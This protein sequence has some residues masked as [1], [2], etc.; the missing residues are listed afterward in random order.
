MKRSVLKTLLS[1][2]I[3][4]GS[5]SPLISA[6]T[7]ANNRSKGVHTLYL[8]RHGD[9]NHKDL[10]DPFT[11]KGLI[12][13]GIAQ[14]RLVAW[15]LRAIPVRYTNLYSS[16]MRRAVETAMVINKDFPY[17]KLQK[18]PILS[19]CTPP[20]WRADVMRKISLEKAKKCS[21]RLDEAFKRFF[22][23]TPDKDTNDIVVCH[24]NVIR[25][26]VTKVLGVNTLSWLRMSIHNCSLTVVKIYSDGA[27]KLV[28]FNDIGHIPPNM[29]T[30]TGGKKKPL[31]IEYDS[32]TAVPA[33]K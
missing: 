16:T 28:S 31:I 3:L 19:E 17:L 24:G 10:R 33:T 13:L 27:M 9:Y 26:F 12:P 22:K 29:Q 18:F 6:P 14:A 21:A 32:S 7:K 11:G 25:Y 30:H 1:I 2:L 23:P 20:T 15:R 4:L 8:I 5:F